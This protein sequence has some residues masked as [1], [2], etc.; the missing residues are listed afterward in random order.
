MSAERTPSAGP[1]G[2]PRVARI[3][4]VGLPGA[5]KST[6]G[7]LVAAALGWAFVDLDT[8]IERQAGRTIPEIFSAEGE[9]GFRRREREATERVAQRR[10]VVLAP[11]GGWMLDPDNVRAVGGAGSPSGDGGGITARDVLLV[12]LRVSASVAAA[13]IGAAA[14]SRPLLAGPNPVEAIERLSALREPTYLQANHT[15]SVDSLTP[16]A[17]ASIIVALAAGWG[18]D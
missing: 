12:F 8:E 9:V 15:V 3:V 14:A 11:G 18:G 5:G 6:V 2:A 7:P 4:L 13:R 17:V 1:P 16:T 10:G